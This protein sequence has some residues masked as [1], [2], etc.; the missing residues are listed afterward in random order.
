MVQ[1]T[2]PKNSKVETGKV[3]NQPKGGA[4]GDFKEFK[5]YRWNP[6]DMSTRTL[7]TKKPAAR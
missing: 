7:S 6:D 2:L 1:L 4:K 3:W 5:I